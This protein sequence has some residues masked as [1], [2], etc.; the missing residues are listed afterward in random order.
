MVSF[1]FSAIGPGGP[2]DRNHRTGGVIAPDAD[3][4]RLEVGELPFPAESTRSRVAL[5]KN[6]NAPPERKGHFH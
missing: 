5:R 1:E 3:I 6:E 4:V 2:L